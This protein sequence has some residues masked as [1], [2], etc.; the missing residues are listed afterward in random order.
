MPTSGLVEV[1]ENNSMLARYDE[2]MTL[3]DQKQ[4]HADHN[5]IVLVHD[6]DITP[7]SQEVP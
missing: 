7:T 4:G 1:I 5:C 2:K 6:A 3:Y